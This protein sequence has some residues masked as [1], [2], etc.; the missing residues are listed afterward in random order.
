MRRRNL[1]V[2]VGL[3]VAVGLS[4]SH[5]PQ[6][7]ADVQQPQN[8]ELVGQA[9]GVSHAMAI[10]GQY[11]YLGIGARLAI[12]D[13][14]NP[15][16]P[17][18]VGQSEMMP[19]V[20]EGVAVAGDYAY[21]VA[22]SIFI[23]D[24]SKPAQP[25]RVGTFYASSYAYGIA[26][27]GRYAY[28]VGDFGGLSIADLSDPVHPHWVPGTISLP[29]RAVGVS[30]VENYA[31]VNCGAAGLQIV[32][33]SDPLQLHAAGL[34]DS[35]GIIRGITAVGNTLY[36]ADS[37]VWSGTTW[38]GGGLRIVDISD[39]ATPRQIGFYDSPGDA[40]AVAVSGVDAF[41]ADG[42]S[43]LR[44]V[45]ISDP[46]RPHEI[47]SVDLA[48]DAYQVS[49]VGTLA[50]IANG[51]A[52]GLQLVDVSDP[53]APYEIGAYT[54]LPGF[55]WDVKVGGDF[56]Y[57]ADGWS[58]LRVVNVADPATPV[59]VSRYD[60]PGYARA[61]A[62]DGHYAYVA[63]GGAGLRIVDVANPLAPR[64]TGACVTPGAATAVVITGTYA[65]VAAGVMGLRVI[66]ISDVT[67]PHE[68]GSYDTAGNT[69]G[70]A[71]RGRY[72]Y[73]ADGLLGLRIIDISNPS[74]PYKV[75]VYNTPGNATG[76]SVAGNFAYVA[77]SGFGL[78]IIDVS[79]PALPQGVSQVRVWEGYAVTVAG[80]LAYVAAGWYGGLVVVDVSQPG[81]AHMSGAYYTS[82]SG[83][84][85]DSKGKFIYVA[86]ADDGVLTLWFSSPVSLAV[87]VIASRLTTSDHTTY[88][89]AADTFSSTV[90]LDHVPRYPGNIPSSRNLI[91]I[92]HAFDVSAV[93][94][95]TGQPAEPARPY[96]LTVQYTDAEKGAAIEDSLALYYWAGGEWVKEP[97]GL[98]K[99]EDNT[100]IATPAHFSLWAVLGETYRF[101]LPM[102]RQ[103]AN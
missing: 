87:P 36:V 27:T 74:A 75:G 34:Y 47:S 40:R 70:M 96:T 103:R 97:T 28:V 102:I 56:A 77:D 80:G 49:L 68:I 51:D 59:E 94:T 79:N 16:Q 32:D 5:A 86:D 93:Y 85:V 54:R 60:T 44:V 43:G 76:V 45:D 55:S 46:D 48:G 8:V 81:L 99:V 53:V 98:V 6:I 78:A 83:V 66:D 13:V 35:P 23:L 33:I 26:I 9:G 22:G 72:A 71:V 10:Q 64:E 41:I 67:R 88:D 69:L 15:R 25:Q 17:S 52:G 100:V 29:D 20:I 19:N 50:F 73:M 62:L 101:Y 90:Q 2:M 57:V 91:G 84:G 82:G 65:L 21:V 14:S 89:F 7:N 42:R 1:L 18:L 31:Y 39:P 4:S 95:A 58:G 63:D 38:V 12:L 24:V 11:V 61:V 37:P 92:G 30:V 3:A